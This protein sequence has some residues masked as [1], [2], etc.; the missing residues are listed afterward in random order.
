MKAGADSSRGQVSSYGGASLTSNGESAK[1]YTLRVKT[2]GTRIP[3][4]APQKAHETPL[5]TRDETSKA[6]LPAA[7]DARPGGL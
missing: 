6:A 2:N 4:E 1:A 5:K 7:R 3:R